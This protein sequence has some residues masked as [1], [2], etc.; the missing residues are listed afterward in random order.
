M[1]TQV[2]SKQFGEYYHKFNMKRFWIIA[3]ITLGIFILLLILSSTIDFDVSWFLAKNKFVTESYKDFEDVWY[4]S[5]NPWDNLVESF[6]DA[7]GPL[8][9]MFG[10]W[11]MAFP[12]F[13]IDK[14]RV[15]WWRRTAQVII[16]A[17]LIATAL[18][19][20]YYY[21]YYMGFN[22]YLKIVEGDFKDQ[23]NYFVAILFSLALNGIVCVLI[24]KFRQSTR[25]SLAKL[26]ALFVIGFIFSEIFIWTLKFQADL[27]RERFRAIMVDYNNWKAT[28]TAGM[29]VIDKEKCLIAFHDWWMKTPISAKT[30]WADSVAW[31]GYSKYANNAFSSF[32]SGHSSLAAC[33]MALCF[34]PCCYDKAG[35]K[36][37]KGY[38]IWLIAL[39]LT[40]TIMFSRVG[41]GAHYL[42]DTTIGF[43]FGAV[44]ML[45]TG[46]IIF[47]IPKV[48]SYL[49][50]MN[51]NGNW[52]HFV[53]IPIILPVVIWLITNVL[54]WA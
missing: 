8:I 9:C 5:Y 27:N 42:S 40:L 52:Y 26:G 25:I 37:W 23:V 15:T 54:P 43:F 34:L 31:L 10:L 33:S 51:I 47:K 3:G 28:G 50:Q 12:F 6:G 46:L 18:W 36:E 44:P 14:V 41:A 4:F 45:I 16:P 32:P 21:N 38:F 24:S 30:Q 35:N 17:F 20:V 29:Y 49:Q 19:I 13:Y 2:K 1:K 7:P 39:G 22:D 48:N 53:I 11:L